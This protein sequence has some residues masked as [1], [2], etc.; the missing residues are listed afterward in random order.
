MTPAA[1]AEGTVLGVDVGG[2]RIKIG[3]VGPTG[4]LGP[5]LSLPTPATPDEV[6]ARIAQHAG[7]L[8]AR[9]GLAPTTPVGVAVPGVID[10]AAGTVE[11]AINLGWE[12]VPVRELLRAALPGPVRVGHDVRAG[13]LAEASWGAG[14]PLAASPGGAPA[15][16]V[17]VPLG[18]GVAAA[19]VHEGHL[20]GDRY[21]GEI[22]QLRVLEPVTGRHM[23]LEEVA[24]ASAIGR[25]YAEAA[26]IAAGAGPDAREVVAR[27]R[28]GE[29]TAEEVLAGALDTLA[30]ALATIV[31]GIGPLPI[32]IGGGLAEGGET[33]LA[34]LRGAIAPRLG[35]IPAP[36]VVP[37]RLGM[38]AGCLG[39]G[40]LA[41]HGD[42][43]DPVVAAAAASSSSAPASASDRGSTWPVG[44]GAGA[45]GA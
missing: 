7:I 25:R 29:R 10:E 6:V 20:L 18:T 43:P 17:F 16:L 8:G 12:Q 32:V 22:G 39:A 44:T 19:V 31:S 28:A 36:P 45:A 33:V 4:E 40:L 41:Q 23:R 24:S 27:A 3:V 38:W 9:A 30:Q 2:T 1:P 21:A 15:D 37:A 11:L 14:R 13:A 34:P 42:G 26:G 5:H 35:A